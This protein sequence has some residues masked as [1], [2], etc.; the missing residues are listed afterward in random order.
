MK[1]LNVSM[2]LI[3]G[4]LLFACKAPNSSPV[5]IQAV[6]SNP[7]KIPDFWLKYRTTIDDAERLDLNVGST[8]VAWRKPFSGSKKENPDWLTIKNSLR[9]GD[10]LWYWESPK[11]NRTQH[12]GFCIIR[13]GMRLLA[14]HLTTSEEITYP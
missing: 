3:F 12:A 6:V 1:P 10:E 7:S 8:I 5:E 2:P 14:K 4:L 9:D 11:V 13:N